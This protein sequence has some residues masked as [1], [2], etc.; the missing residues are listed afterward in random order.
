MIRP[1]YILCSESRI[2]D[3]ATGLVTHYNV[4]DELTLGVGTSKPLAGG[5]PMLKFVMT[6]VWARVGDE[7]SEDLFEFETYIHMPGE[8]NAR[9]IHAGEFAFGEHSFHR[10]EAFVAGIVVAGPP[11]EGI[12]PADVLRFASGTRRLESRVRRSG[13]NEWLAQDYLIPVRVEQKTSELAESS[14]QD[15]GE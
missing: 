9:C 2:V 15:I 7:D 11:P 12:A 10:L 8:E 3:R 13:D 1:R 14:Q 6:A 4:V 5:L